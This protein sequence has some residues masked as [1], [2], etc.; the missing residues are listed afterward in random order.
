MQQEQTMDEK[1]EEGRKK[2]NQKIIKKRY[3]QAKRI[4]P[5]VTRHVKNASLFCGLAMVN[6]DHTIK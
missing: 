4:E 3:R 1:K 2:M 5:E 6:T